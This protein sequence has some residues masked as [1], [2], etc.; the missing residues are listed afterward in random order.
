[1]IVFWAVA[2][3]ALFFGIRV[4]M[5]EVTKS[6]MRWQIAHLEYE[7]RVLLRAMWDDSEQ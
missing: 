4:C 1:M 2:I 7:R 5:L 6:R 3:V